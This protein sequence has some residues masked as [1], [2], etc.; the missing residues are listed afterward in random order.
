MEVRNVQSSNREIIELTPTAWLEL[1]RVYD[2]AEASQWMERLLGEVALEQRSIIL[3]GKEVMQ[4]RLIGWAGDMPYTYSR[5]TLPPRAMGPTV[6]DL[7]RVTE[8][9]SGCSFNHALINLYRD[10]ADSMGMHSDSEPELGHNP[11]VASWSFGAQRQF[12]VAQK[13]GSQRLRLALPS[14]SLLCMKGDVQHTF[15]HGLP[16]QRRLLLPRLNVTFRALENG[17]GAF[18]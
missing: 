4:P 14:G 16:K 7:L 13:R 5:S 18:G 15:V 17:A 8:R 9:L 12:M 2:P 1:F 6:A 11:T 3:F 10:G